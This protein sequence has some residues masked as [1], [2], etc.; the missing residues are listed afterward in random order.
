MQDTIVEGHVAGRRLDW[1]IRGRTR[2]SGH[3][4][5]VRGNMACFSGQDG[6]GRINQKGSTPPGLQRPGESGGKG[7]RKQEAETKVLQR[8]RQDR[9]QRKGQ[10]RGN[11]ERQ[12]TGR[13]RGD[14]G[15]QR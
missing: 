4:P 5:R 13:G 14:A 11:A 9:K 1:I 6:P 8:R 15:Q 3:N 10:R 2:R 12:R 7:R